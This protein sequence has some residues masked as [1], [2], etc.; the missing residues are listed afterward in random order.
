MALYL[1]GNCRPVRME[2]RVIETGFKNVK[3]EFLKG[4]HPSEIITAEKE[5]KK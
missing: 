5:V 2:E 4:L 3:R 1:M